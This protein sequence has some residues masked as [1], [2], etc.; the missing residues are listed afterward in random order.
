[1]TGR[2]LED[3]VEQ[4]KLDINPNEAKDDDDL[5]DWICDEMKLTKAPAKSSRR[6]TTDDDDDASRLR[7]M[8]EGRRD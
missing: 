7:K 8:R 5:A 6:A 3:L 4:E 2:E 1:M